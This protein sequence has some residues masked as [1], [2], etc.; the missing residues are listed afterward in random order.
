MRHDILAAFALTLWLVPVTTPVSTSAFERFD[1]DQRYLVHAGFIIKDHS[2]V[3]AADG[4]IHIFYIKADETL[5]ESQR[6]KALGHATTTDLVHWTY[7]PDVIPVVPE[8]WE[9]S[10]IWAPHVVQSNG[11]WY[12]FYTGVNR[13]YAQA[14]G[15]AI[16]VDLFTWVKSGT[17]PVYTPDPG[18]ATW[19][20][21]SWS[22]CRDPF[23]V[24]DD[25]GAWHLLTTAWTNNSEGAISHATSSDLVTW[26]DQGPLFVHPGPKAWHV[27]E[28]ANLHKVNGTWHLTFTEQNVGGSSYLNAANLVGP[29][30]YAV[31]EPFDAGHAT[32]LFQIDGQWMISRHTTFASDGLPRYTIKFDDAD[33]NTPDKPII[34]FTDPLADWTIWSGDAF[35]L[36]PTFW[37]N[38]KERGGD[39]SNFAG[40]SWIGTY[41]LFTGP[42]QIGFPGLSM[43]ESP[44]GALRSRTFTLTGDRISF[45][46]GGGND[47]DN[48]YLGLYTADDGVLRKRATGNDSDAMTQVIWAVPELMGRPVFL[49]IADYS[50]AAWGHVNVDEIIE[51]FDGT[52]PTDAGDVQLPGVLSLQQNVPNPFNPRTT[53]GLDLPAD[54]R[55]RLVIF[56]VRGR[57]IRNLIDERL[58]AGP[59]QVVWNGTD[60]AGSAVPSGVYYYRLEI[61]NRAPLTRSMLLVR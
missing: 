42:L 10:F 9:E 40:N 25:A 20:Q 11:V 31:R 26:N 13:F 61:D 18:W 50:D 16:S 6:A 58:P 56:D 12:M 2:V 29:W 15:L 48:L 32:E 46:I 36:Q 24:Q 27:L 7:H 51:F 33:W 52:P 17:N 45:L 41:E 5:P 38:S 37:D 8:T 39:A 4:T 3:Q 21:N 30:D 34:Q 60:H 19:S 57:W 49:E 43:G 1:F 44:K 59:H 28:S 53:I 23:V 14:T 55:A 35:Y 54:R 47:I 22:N